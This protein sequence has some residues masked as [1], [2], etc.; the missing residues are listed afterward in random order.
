LFSYF[1]DL[2]GM[3]LR[4]TI[5]D[6]YTQHGQEDPGADEF[7][8][9]RREEFSC[10]DTA[11][12]PGRR[13]FYKISL[14]T[15]GEGH[16]RYADQSVYINR[17][18]LTV[19]NP[20][21]PYAWQPASPEQVGYFCVFTEDFV[22]RNMKKESLAQSMLFQARGSHV[23]FPSAEQV[24]FLS[25]MF[26][27]MLREAGSPYAYRHELLRH[28]VQIVMHEALKMQPPD[29]FGGA[30]GSASQRLSALF[31][32]LLEQQF[33][34]E[35]PRQVLR[36]KNA[37]EFAAALH[38]HTNHLNRAL[39]ETTGKTTTEWITQRI[40]QEAKALLMYSGWSLADVAYCLGFEHATNFHLFFKRHTGQTPGQFRESSVVSHS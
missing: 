19:L 3:D 24:T 16:F 35:S 17:P 28:Y 25:A 1:T 9:Y 10:D 27:N 38:V 29:P 30:A 8:I 31:A 5:K 6:F 13:D 20:L 36:L 26:E 2:Y 23:L 11:L 37:N 39:K 15:R 18:A 21:V 12:Q 40:T 32:D 33:P 7:N 34:I 14:V 4:E 22:S